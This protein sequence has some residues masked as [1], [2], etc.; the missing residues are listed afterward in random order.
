LQEGLLN[1]LQIL[2]GFKEEGLSWVIQ[3]PF[4]TFQ[5]SSIPPFQTSGE[6]SNSLD[7]RQSLDNDFGCG[8]PR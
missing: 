4:P 1:R 3:V 2:G 6:T 8:Y 5:Y 7:N